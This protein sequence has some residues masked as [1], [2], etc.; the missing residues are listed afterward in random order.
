MP[1]GFVFALVGILLTAF[2]AASNPAI[3]QHS[4]GVNV[5]L[6]WGLVLLAFGLIMVMLGRR[7]MRKLKD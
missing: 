6:Y 1:I 5:N 7:G 3:Y 2:G 4:L